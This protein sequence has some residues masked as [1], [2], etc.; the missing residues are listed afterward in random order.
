MRGEG[1]E[2]GSTVTVAAP[3]QPITL[4]RGPALGYLRKCTRGYVDAAG[5]GVAECHRRRRF[6]VI[7]GFSDESEGIDGSAN[8]KIC[9]CGFT[10]L[11]S[12]LCSRGTKL[13]RL[14]IVTREQ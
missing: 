4:T 11:Q 9:L 10:H 6:R 14:I 1:T 3:S 2:G 7:H 12:L 5:W 13:R 8:A